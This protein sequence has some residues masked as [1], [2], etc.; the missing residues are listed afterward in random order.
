[1]Y[2]SEE[3]I[4]SVPQTAAF[5]DAFLSQGSESVKPGKGFWKFDGIL[6]ILRFNGSCQ[7]FLLIADYLETDSSGILDNSSVIS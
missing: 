2:Y 6:W 4:Y 3:P 5:T 1:M 7:T